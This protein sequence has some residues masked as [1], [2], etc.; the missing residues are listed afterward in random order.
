[1]PE[2]ID[3]ELEIPVDCGSRPIAEPTDPHE[4]NGEN[5]MDAAQ[6]HAQITTMLA[7]TG[8]V[9]QNNFVTVQKVVDYDF[10]ENKR[11]VTLDE[12]VGVREVASKSVPAGPTSV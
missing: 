2:P 10:L 5:D 6:L 8:A 11:I 1:M 9:A 4:P 7:Q 12:A 3:G